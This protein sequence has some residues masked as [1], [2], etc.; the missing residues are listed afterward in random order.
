[1]HCP[2]GLDY[3]RRPT[4]SPAWDCTVSTNL[5]AGEWGAMV[6]D[7]IGV[8]VEEVQGGGGEDGGDAAGANRFEDVLG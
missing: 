8:V 1:M 2:E 4:E 7:G 6:A 5:G 3:I